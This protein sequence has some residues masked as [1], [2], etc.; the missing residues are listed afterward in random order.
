MEEGGRGVFRPEVPDP[1]MCQA[2]S[3]HL[4]E[5]STLMVC[6][7]FSDEYLVDWITVTFS[8]LYDYYQ[9]QKAQ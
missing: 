1:E 2:S 4:W 9:K 5:L 3:A 6:V 8:R 7:L